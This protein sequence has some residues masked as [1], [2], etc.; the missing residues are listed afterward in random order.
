[1]NK[2][3][4]L[5]LLFLHRLNMSYIAKYVNSLEFNSFN[6]VKVNASF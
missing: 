4:F 6:E 1:M 5:D 2:I 3:S